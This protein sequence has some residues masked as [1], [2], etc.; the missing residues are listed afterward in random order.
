MTIEKSYI[1]DKD[2]DHPSHYKKSTCTYEVIEVI[3][4]WYLDFR[5]ANTVKYVGRAGDKDPSKYYEDLK[6]AQWYILRYMDNPPKNRI[7]NIICFKLFHKITWQDVTSDWKLSGSRSVIL[8][9]LYKSQK[10]FSKHNK[11][12]L[13]EAIK[14]LKEEIEPREN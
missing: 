5:L 12:W 10:F 13:N 1:N 7:L 9:A 4:D 8:M 2:I 14:I 11:L 3:E 6:K